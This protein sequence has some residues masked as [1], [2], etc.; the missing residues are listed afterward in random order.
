M[1][2]KTIRMPITRKFQSKL[3]YARLSYVQRIKDEHIYMNDKR[4]FCDANHITR[5]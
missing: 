5:C 1:K 4:M 3:T 2:K